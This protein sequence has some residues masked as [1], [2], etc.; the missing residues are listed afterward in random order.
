MTDKCGSTGCISR[1]GGAQAG[2]AGACAALER[3]TTVLNIPEMCCPTE[4]SLVEKKL[5]Q[6]DGVLN[7]TAD[8]MRRNVRVEHDAVATT[9]LLEAAQR[10]GMEVRLPTPDWKE[11]RSTIVIEK[12]DCPTEEALIRQRLSKE[13]WVQDLSFNLLQRKLTVE[14]AAGRL[15]DVLAALNEIGMNGL[16][17]R[18]EAPGESTQPQGSHAGAYWKL[19]IGGALALTSELV[20][21]QLGD[22]SIGVIGLALAAIAVSGVETYRKGW[23]AVRHLNL[24][25]NALMSVAVTGAAILGQW[26]E[27]AMVMVLFAIAEMIE[28]RS[29]DRARRAVEGLMSMAPETATVNTP[30]GWRE[31]P[32]ADVAVGA[33]VRAR[34]GERIALDGNVSSGSSAVDQSPITGESVPVDK[35]VGDAVY[36]GTINQDG[37]LEYRVTAA[38]SNSTLARIAHAVQ[39]AQGTRAP[40]Q[41]FV[42]TFS[43][44]YTPA[45]FAA[46]IAI[47][48]IPPLGMGAD[49]F[50]WVY[51]ALVLLVVACPCAL[52][53]STPVT[54]V[55]GLTAAA[56]RGILIKGG[57]F[58]EQGHRLQV[59]ALDKTGTLTQGRPVL[60][61]V[62]ALAGDTPAL[63][64]LAAALAARSDH[65][66]SRAVA[67]GLKDSADHPEVSGFSALRGRGVE[68]SMNGVLYRLGNH[69]LVEESG[70]CSE[71]LEAKLDALEKEGKTAIVLTA[72]AKALAIFA[73]ADVVRPESREAVAQL[74]QLGIRP[75]MLTGDN[76]HTA[77]AIARQ[78]GITDVRSEL[79]PEE[80]LKAIEEFA[81]GNAVVGMVGD[82]INDAPALAK[83]NIGFAMGAVGTDAAIETA[84]VALMDD[85]PRKL[86]EFVKLSRATKAVLWQN[87]SFAIGIKVVFLSLALTGQ[88]N[89]WMAVFA[90]MGGSLLV[91]FN[92]LRLLRKKA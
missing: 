13:L 38:A 57:V 35:V 63:S 66:V 8:F 6:L 28:A 7:V 21:L 4:F 75:V 16:P 37:E 11:E 58:L 76:R 56:R 87:I 60:T 29:L 1:S 84:D 18:R 36:A 45:V 61:D 62:I 65:P 91:V 14:H 48:L 31:V 78:V 23:I 49:W 25:I 26:P 83:A 72:G 92:G 85:D 54:V 86:A 77:E 82:G 71:D 19:A 79:L 34:P 47:A 20:A 73:V 50:T 17:Q 9:E 89:L 55:S 70:A 39:E 27:A 52:V 90:D 30:S 41:R 44:Y 32:A 80:K 33:T 3:A 51:R 12:M 53:I 15:D 43:R 68:G 69:R 2:A 81:A 24:N 22:S 42:D 88:A 67:A 74:K 46:A 10:S 59:L 40:T 64:T 5:R